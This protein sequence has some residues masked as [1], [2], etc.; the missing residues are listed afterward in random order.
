MK[1]D[2]EV[3]KL[4]TRE[5]TTASPEDRVS[6]VHA[7]MRKE[8]IHHIAVVDNGRFVGLLSANDLLRIAFGDPYRMDPELV[9]KD[10]ELFKAREVMA[11]DVVTISPTQSV[12][13]AAKKLADGAFH[14]LP[15]V[16]DD[17]LV[18]I[19]TSTDLIL[20]LIDD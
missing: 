9:D 16:E 17:Q 7:V 11:E 4:M 19:V 1:A 5:P 3:S 15:V 8:G 18:G 10:L 12:R 2:V 20:Y 6:S 13:D 14:A